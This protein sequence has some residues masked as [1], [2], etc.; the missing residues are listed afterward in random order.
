MAVII[1]VVV[2]VIQVLVSIVAA[3]EGTYITNDL[4]KHISMFHSLVPSMQMNEMVVCRSALSPPLGPHPLPEQAVR[5]LV[6]VVQT[7][8]SRGDPASHTFWPFDG[9]PKSLAE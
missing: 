2:V 6:L 5:M 4:D 3:F 9:Y 8:Y 7:A 1:V